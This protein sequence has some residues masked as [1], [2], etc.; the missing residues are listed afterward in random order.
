MLGKCC[1][2]QGY[3]GFFTQDLRSTLKE[4][5]Y[6]VISAQSS[7]QCARYPD[8]AIPS[9]STLFIGHLARQALI[10]GSP[11]LGPELHTWLPLEKMAVSLIIH[12]PS[13]SDVIGLSTQLPHVFGCCY[14]AHLFF[15]VVI[16]SEKYLHKEFQTSHFLLKEME[17]QKYEVNSPTEKNLDLSSFSSQ[18][19]GPW[20]VQGS[21][22]LLRQGVQ[23]SESSYP[24]T[25]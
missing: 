15:Q 6:R 2:K 4:L 13:S 25:H 8:L 22:K 12:W 21:R 9:W 24:T 11:A 14:F 16:G 10:S 23:S 5:N 17:A 20:P 18:A 7:M 19:T 3:T 1:I